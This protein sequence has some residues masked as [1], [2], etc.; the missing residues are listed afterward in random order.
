MTIL[1]CCSFI[2]YTDAANGCTIGYRTFQW[3]LDGIGDE[4]SSLYYSLLVLST[5]S[6]ALFFTSYSY[7]AHSL[8]KVLDLLT[9]ENHSEEDSSVMKYSFLLVALNSAVWVSVFLLWASRMYNSSSVNVFDSIAQY[10]LATAA[11]VTCVTFGFH[12]KRVLLFLKRFVHRNLCVRVATICLC[13]SI[14]CVCLF[15]CNWIT[16]CLKYVILCMKKVIN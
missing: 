14:A 12:L 1:F 16:I 9:A 8:S 10:S 2:W 15:F 6:S 4:N 5:S 7:F 13:F 11:L 3:E